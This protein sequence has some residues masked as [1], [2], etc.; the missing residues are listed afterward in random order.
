MASPYLFCRTDCN[1]DPIELRM[2]SNEL[3]KVMP[4][5]DEIIGFSP[6]KR[7]A[8]DYMCP[9]LQH[10]FGISANGKVFP[11]NAMFYEV[12]DIRVNRLGEI[13]LSEK[14]SKVKYAELFPVCLQSCSNKKHE[15]N[16]NYYII[17]DI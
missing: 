8:D 2:D 14:L 10:S 4:V 16:I 5:V 13:W 11:C 7:N 1:K 15:M 9:T 6:Q 3:K 12:G 17:C